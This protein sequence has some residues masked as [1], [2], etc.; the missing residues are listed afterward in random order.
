MRNLYRMLIKGYE[1]VL[2][3]LYPA[4]WVNGV[5]PPRITGL[6]ETEAEEELEPCAQ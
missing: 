2:P 3:P 4:E 6:L 1:L 5:K